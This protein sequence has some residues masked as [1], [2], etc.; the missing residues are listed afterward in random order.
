MQ[1][2]ERTA[3]A[4]TLQ[5]SNHPYLNG[6]WTPQHEELTATD[7]EVIE[8]RIPAD[9]DG[10]YLRNTE[11]QL[12]QPLGKYHPFDG[13]GMVHQISFAGGT[14]SYRNRFV[15]TRCLA[16][17]QEAGGSLWGGLM[18][19]PGTSKRPGFG[20]H[21]GLKDS[22]STDIIVHAGKALSTFYQC[23]E[24]YLLDPETLAPLGLAPWV[25]LDGISAHPKVDE[26]TGELLFFNYS[27]HAPY[28]HYGV[29]DAGGTLV[30]YIPVPLPGPRLPHDMIFSEH[31]SIVNDLPMF[32]DQ[33]LLQRG[34]HAARL[35]QGIPSR[36]GLIPRHGQPEEIR[37][38]EAAPTYI[39]HFLN[40]YEEGDEV[41]M[42]A[43]FQDNPQ[44]APLPNEDGY[45]H[46]MAYVDEHSFQPKLHRWRFNLADGTTKEERLD[47]R[48]LEFGMINQQ[49]AGRKHR[50]V[51]STTTRP[52][53]F[54][55]N[56]F[57]KH[58]L[59]TG[60]SW[61][62][63]LDEGRYAS[64]APF[65]PRLG[66]TAEDDGYLVSFITDENRGTSECVLIDA[67]DIAAGPVCRI[68]LP[69][70]ISSGTHSWW[71]DRASLG[72]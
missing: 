26:A 39:L 60:D 47:D 13:D 32:W 34:L 61:S 20:A 23:G 15:R 62:L 59:E 11:N 70:K 42:D 57:V 41:V 48:I 19:K 22:S 64:E 21:G 9:I 35:H 69:H 43:Y 24:G 3:L 36:F 33:E 31:W 52:G 51:Y 7:L 28:M 1:I 45:G 58:D 25:P 27:K 55:F 67:R 56:G 5:P 40:A 44:P 4:G 71:A 53:W 49:V 50:Y 46:M 68:A 18:D 10:V 14:A 63:M 2:L 12:H 37:W 54:L 72:S 65:A 6:A 38:F 17:E 8:G 16:A 30:H 66:S 29:V